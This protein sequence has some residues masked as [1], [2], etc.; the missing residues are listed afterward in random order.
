MPVPGLVDRLLLMNN[1]ADQKGTVAR[2]SDMSIVTWDDKFAT[3]IELIDNQ[4]R[5]L[6]HLTNEL[7]R[8]CRMGNETLQ[9]VFKE[10]MGRMVDYVRFHFRAELEILQSIQYPDYAAHK[11]EHD[12][13]VK[14]IL[15]AAKDHNEGKKFIPNSFV[16][17]LKDW[18]FGH[19]AVTD[20]L[21]ALYVADQKRKGLLS[22][23]DIL[24]YSL[25]AKGSA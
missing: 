22:D 23:Q 11:N 5:Q 13:L 6:V 21:Y 8:A 4:H 15:D 19:I 25:A 18:V 10:S 17:T 24:N 14:N 3:G 12:T 7:Y 20:R 1:L 16:R 2:S 9:T